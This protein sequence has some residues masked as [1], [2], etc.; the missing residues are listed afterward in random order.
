MTLESEMHSAITLIDRRKTRDDDVQMTS[1]QSHD[2]RKTRDD[3]ITSHHISQMT[4]ERP[5]WCVQKDKH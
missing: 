5:N 2:R 4:A 1:H 3:D